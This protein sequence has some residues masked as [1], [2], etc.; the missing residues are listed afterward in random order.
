MSEPLTRQQ[1]RDQ[2]SDA[3]DG[4]LDDEAREAFELLLA[5]DAELRQEYEEFAEVL[6]STQS[7]AGRG[8]GGAPDLLPGIR[9]KIKD[10]HDPRFLSKRFMSKQVRGVPW[11]M[12]V[13]TALLLLI[14][15]V[16]YFGWSAITELIAQ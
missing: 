1:A 12:I 16:G 6:E 5:A 2:F 7:L 10:R 11:V 14:A 3:F 15:G 13:L 4:L 8:A 9:R